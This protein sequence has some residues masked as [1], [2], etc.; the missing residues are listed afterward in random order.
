MPLS[1]PVKE[2]LAE[3]LGTEV[4]GWFPV[5]ARGVRHPYAARSAETGETELTSL[6]GC[7]RRQETFRCRSRS[8]MEFDRA[9][10][11]TD[12]S[13]YGREGSPCQ[14]AGDAAPS[15]SG[16]VCEKMA[17]T[18]HASSHP[19]G[20]GFSTRRRVLVATRRTIGL[21]WKAANGIVVNQVRRRRSA[22]WKQASRST[23]PAKGESTCM[24]RRSKS[25]EKQSEASPWDMGIRRRTTSD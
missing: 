16:A 24:P 2:S 3:A 9:Q 17:T 12:H 15:T 7:Y 14:V 19:T 21:R 22:R 4:C 18:P 11:R 20:A 1:F 25:T 5:G 13:A 8:P 10:H 23:C 6:S